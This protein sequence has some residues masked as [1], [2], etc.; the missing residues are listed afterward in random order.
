MEK[1]KWTGAKLYFVKEAPFVG[2]SRIEEV[3]DEEEPKEI[4]KKEISDPVS[5]PGQSGGG[6]GEEGKPN[7]QEM[8][9]Y[10]VPDHYKTYLWVL[11]P[12]QKR[13]ELTVAKE[14]HLLRTLLMSL[15]NKAQVE[16]IVDPGCQIVAM[17]E[18]ICHDYG[19]SYEVG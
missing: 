7:K 9:G 6:S 1:V 16:C 15:D 17:S 3:F 18:A 13:L 2:R 10:V 19:L 12:G 11:Q 4:L 14:L 5:S 8:A